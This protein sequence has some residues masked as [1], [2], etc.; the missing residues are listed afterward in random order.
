[1]DKL[2]KNRTLKKLRLFFSSSRRSKK[3]K[4][5]ECRSDSCGVL[6]VIFK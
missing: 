3:L 5:P 4:S 6:E 2:R 1:M